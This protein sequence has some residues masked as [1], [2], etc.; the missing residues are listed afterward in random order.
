M[1]TPAYNLTFILEIKNKQKSVI[2]GFR[3]VFGLV[4][5]YISFH[6]VYYNI[7]KKIYQYVIQNKEHDCDFCPKSTLPYNKTRST[8]TYTGYIIQL[9]CS[10]SLLQLMLYII[11]SLSLPICNTLN[12]NLNIIPVAHLHASTFYITGKNRA[13][14]CQVTCSFR[15][16][17]E[18]GRTSVKT[19]FK[20]LII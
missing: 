8:H 1:S 11:I 6:R 12:N 2:K 7:R 5:S 14:S 4:E 3:K 20:A 15:F 16:Y 17:L 13:L 10:W 19:Q 9:Y 18:I